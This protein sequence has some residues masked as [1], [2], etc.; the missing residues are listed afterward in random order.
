MA[1]TVT[2]W[3]IHYD[4]MQPPEYW[5]KDCVVCDG[6]GCEV[7]MEEEEPVGPAPE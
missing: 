4:R 7:C 2:E 3:Q 6:D 5:H 1:T